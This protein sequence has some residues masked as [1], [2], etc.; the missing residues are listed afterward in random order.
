M[1]GS[2]RD[3]IDS[4]RRAASLTIH[5]AALDHAIPSGDAGALSRSLGHAES[6]EPVAAGQHAV[7]GEA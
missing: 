1:P 2:A 7:A 5:C 6:R 3:G 4:D